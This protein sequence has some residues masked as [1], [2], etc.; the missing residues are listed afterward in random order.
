[1]TTH[2]SEPPLV[3]FDGVCH[4][5][6]GFV[7]FCIRHDPQKRLR[8]GAMQSEGAQA[9]LR[10]HGLAL[11]DFQSFVLIEDDIVHQRSDG[12]LRV[13]RRLRRPWSWLALLRGV[14]RPLRDWAYDLIARNRF[15]L[16][17]RRSTCMTPSPEL[18]DRFV[19]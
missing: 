14:P 18:A 3:L 9:L 6:G 19:A 1:M 15:R 11:T 4:L 5:C 7:A 8:F 10:R 16:F 17:G 13:V 12:F 2:P